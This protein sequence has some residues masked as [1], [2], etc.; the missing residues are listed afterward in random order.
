MTVK[1]EN[2]IVKLASDQDF[3]TEIQK[4]E[5]IER[6]T[7]ILQLAGYTEEESKQLLDRLNKA[8]ETV[9]QNGDMNEAELEAVCGGGIGG[10]I[11]GG[12]AGFAA[13]LAAHKGWQDTL[14]NTAAGATVGGIFLPF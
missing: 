7:K 11:I 13:S 8:I 14:R 6:Y 3:R 5:V 9:D 12:V 1:S 4:P 10:A 2:I